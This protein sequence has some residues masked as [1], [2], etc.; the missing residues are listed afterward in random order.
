MRHTHSPKHAS[1]L[2]AAVFCLASLQARAADP[3]S[4][5]IK[6]PHPKN[7]YVTG[8]LNK[9]PKIGSA[10]DPGGMNGYLNFTLHSLTGLAALAVKEGRGDSMIWLNLEDSGSYKLWLG[11]I[12]NATK[13]KR[14]DAPD[15]M[16][17]IN[18]FI[19]N[20]TVKGYIL[21]RADMSERDLY[22]SDPE[23][24]PGYDA[25]VNVATTMAPQLGAI[26]VE[27]SAEPVIKK[28]GLKRLF[29]ARGKDEKWCFANRRDNCN[30]ALLCTIEPKV[31]HCR[32][33][34]IATRSFCFF[35]V[36]R[37]TSEVMA[38]AGP[39][40]PLV[41]WNSG[42]EDV[43][44][45]LSSH[46]GKFETA[47]NWCLN[48]TLTSIV[49]A[50]RDISWPELRL[51]KDSEVD[52]LALKWEEGVH[53]TS[54]IMTD[55]DNVQWYMG[56]FFSNSLHYWNS[57]GRAEFPIGWTA[58]PADLAQI[59]VPTI[60]WMA[61]TASPGDS[62][63]MLGGGYYY[64]EIYGTA[65]P[66][67]I[68][69]LDGHIAQIA[70]WM[71]KLGVRTIQFNNQ[72]WDS[73]DARRAQSR[74]A[75][76]IPG[77]VGIF[78]IQYYP[79]TG[80]EGR[81][82]WTPNA[83]GDPIPVIS[84]RY[85]LWEHHS[86][87]KN[88]GPPA[89]VASLINK[90]AHDGPPTS[91]AYLDWTTVHVWSYFK[92]AD[93][94]RDL[95]AEEVDQKLANSPN[96]ERGVEPLKWCVDRLEPHVKVVSPEE[97]AWRARIYL[98]TRETLDGIARKLKT[99]PLQH[100]IFAKKIDDYRAWLKNVPLDTPAQRRHAFNELRAIR[101]GKWKDTKATIY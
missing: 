75:L 92:K 98:K 14:I 48:L 43:Q 60:E 57:P 30:P 38:W 97:L 32:D 1:L 27:E 83:E 17:L 15:S 46:W 41:G 90:A 64:P 65:Y 22:C 89:V 24:T 84:A 20:G 36:N 2:L 67:P 13:A 50:G 47:T 77:L 55:G 9:L 16:S 3:A 10:S 45:S 101:F 71:E 82:L 94:S 34:A 100:A 44:T 70:P 31:P 99:A 88:E 80:G 35:G 5:W 72:R 51:N 95:W 52:P 93:T 87:I 11:S 21:Y 28:M 19:T 69:V 6:F 39:N 63:M 54:F 53:Y 79:Y 73:A 96:V 25:S 91:D 78:S 18:T 66:D 59:A 76:H 4:Y 61:R 37:F 86:S 68:K 23:T 81:I 29:D 40:T 42:A 12:F 26:I 62:F 85:G 7:I 56:G 8:D 33:Y 74:Y 58:P 49:Q